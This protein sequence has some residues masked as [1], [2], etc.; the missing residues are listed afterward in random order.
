MKGRGLRISRLVTEPSQDQRQQGWSVWFATRILLLLGFLCIAA[1]YVVWGWSNEITDLGGDSSVYML[2]ARYF[3]P[4]WASSPVFGEFAKSMAYPPLFPVLIGMLGGSMLAG[5][6]LVV[7]SLLAA[8]LCLYAWLRSE[9]LGPCASG[10][11]CL[12]FALMPG[13]YLQALNIWSENLYLFLS[14]LA[15]AIESRAE[16]ASPDRPSLWWSAAAAVAAASLVR[17][18]AL[19]LLAAFAMRLLII[20][21]RG[22][23]SLIVACGIPFASWTVWGKLHQS[24]GNDYISQWTASYAHDPIG[25]MAVQVTT[26]ASLVLRGWVESWLGE[27]GSNS[28]FY[29]SLAAGGLGLVGWLRRLTQFKFDA[30]YVLLYSSLLLVW[31]FPAEARRL[32]YVLIPILVAQG[33]LLFRPCRE[34]SKSL[35]RLLLPLWLGALTIAVLPSLILTLH[36]FNEALPPELIGARHIESWYAEDRQ[37]AI[38]S[39]RSLTTILANL[40]EIGGFVPRDGCIFAIKPSVVSLYSDRSTYAPPPLSA[41]REAFEL[42]IAKCKY[43]YVLAYS[44]PSFRQAFY[45]LDR[46]NERVH[47][48]TIA[49]SG[50]GEHAR[51]FGA[52]VEI[53]P[54]TNLPLEVESP[55]PGHHAASQDSQDEPPQR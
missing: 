11:A 28:L 9:G 41:S 7:A 51:T 38:D 23:R 2:A 19:P 3:S 8:I 31:P 6:L 25:T 26:E 18:A 46:L 13:T 55:Q 42:G 27:T 33:L 48:L 50:E 12:I 1:G 22:W 49:G 34:S 35:P 14:L 43:A 21:P 45:P 4:F 30:F 29:L 5:H 36:R 10:C 37:Q 24:I 17:A 53:Q 39:S 16:T 44:S 40:R 47:S 52:L 15:I 32:S 20:R 54:P